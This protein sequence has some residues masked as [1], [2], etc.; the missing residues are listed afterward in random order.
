MS[1]NIIAPHETYPIRQKVLWPQKTISQIAL[2]EDPDGLHL[3]KF[4]QDGQLIGVISIFFSEKTVQFKKLAV[5]ETHQ[6]KGIGSLL[7]SEVKKVA[8]L[9]RCVKIICDA[10]QAAVPFYIKH[11]FEKDYDF[12][13]Y[14]TM[15]VRMSYML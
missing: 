6:A 5:L 4:S 13:K 10:R 2:P 9:R 1:V 12:L 3:G 14:G 8:I 11:G 15:Y 7:V